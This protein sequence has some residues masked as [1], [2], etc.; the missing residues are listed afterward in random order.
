MAG[1]AGHVFSS[2]EKASH[3]FE[4]MGLLLNCS[5][6]THSCCLSICLSVY[7]SVCVGSFSALL[8]NSKTVCIRKIMA[9]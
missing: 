3:C 1:T 4:A 7:L 6:L 5:N 8:R 9:F 2:L